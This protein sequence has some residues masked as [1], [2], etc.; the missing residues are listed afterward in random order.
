[1]T[2]ITAFVEENIHCDRKSIIGEKEREYIM[3]NKVV[4]ICSVCGFYSLKTI[5]SSK[6]ITQNILC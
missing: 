3:I 4:S 5:P 2:A 6:P 1:M